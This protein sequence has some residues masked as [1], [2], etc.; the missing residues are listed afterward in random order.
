MREKKTTQEAG[1]ERRIVRRSPFIVLEVKWKHYDKIFIGYA[2]NI[3]A[4]GLFLPSSQP[5]KVG[6]RFPVEFVLPD[7][8]TMVR[9]TCE[10]VWKKRYDTLGLV[11]EGMGIKFVDLDQS[12]RKAIATWVQKQEGKEGKK[13]KS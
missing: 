6:D 11:S 1:I 5:M 4:G 3:G 2:E 9:C 10:V 12:K 13:K 8:E 7:N